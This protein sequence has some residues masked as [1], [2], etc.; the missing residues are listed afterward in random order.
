MQLL[1]ECFT[2]RERYCVCTRKSTIQSA[3]WNM[4]FETVFTCGS[5]SISGFCHEQDRS[6][7][8]PLIISHHLLLMHWWVQQCSLLPASEWPMNYESS[9]SSLLIN[10]IRF[11]LSSF[12]PFLASTL[13]HDCFTGSHNSLFVWCGL[14]QQITRCAFTKPS[15]SLVLSLYMCH[16]Q[17]LRLSADYGV[18]LIDF[19]P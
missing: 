12:L 6:T 19:T 18:K 8:S 10:L 5:R 1:L 9:E 13:V 17:P 3:V 11:N 7:N 14:T 4:G 16:F 15:T 2:R